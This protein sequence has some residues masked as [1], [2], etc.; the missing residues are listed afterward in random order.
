[1]GCGGEGILLER[2]KQTQDSL[3]YFGKMRGWKR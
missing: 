3:W 1:M 2:G